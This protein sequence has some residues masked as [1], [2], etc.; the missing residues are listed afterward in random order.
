VKMGGLPVLILGASMLFLGLTIFTETLLPAELAIVSV[1]LGLVF[2]VFSFRIRQGR[3]ASLPYLI[4]AFLAYVV[5]ELGMALVLSVGIF[6]IGVS[7]IAVV[8]ALH[9]AT[10]L[11]VALAARGLRGWR[12]MRQADIKM[13][14]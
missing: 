14:F 8:L 4:G 11:A 10:F 2:I 6:G 5:V 7:N 13:Q 9:A 1:V 3:S 12:Y